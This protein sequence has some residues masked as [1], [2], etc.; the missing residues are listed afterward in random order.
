M[1]T[2]L[3]EMR[4]GCF[5]A[6]TD[7]EPMFILLARDPQAPAL[8]RK[9]ALERKCDIASGARPASDMGKVFEAEECAKR[10]ELWRL[11]NDGA[12]RKGLF[13]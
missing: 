9:W 1:G 12:W 7:D 6:A 13:K 10:M 5:A 11:E 3:E 8:I 4:N 2:K